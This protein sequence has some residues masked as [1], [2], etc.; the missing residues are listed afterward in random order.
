MFEFRNQSYS[1][2]VVSLLIY[3]NSFIIVIIVAAATNQIDRIAG[4]IINKNKSSRVLGFVSDANSE[5]NA[6][7]ISSSKER[8]DMSEHFRLKH[9]E[10]SCCLLTFILVVVVVSSLSCLVA[11]S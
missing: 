8:N 7:L 5:I 4:F 10:V 9:M 3:L 11:W 2:I 1:V 6:H